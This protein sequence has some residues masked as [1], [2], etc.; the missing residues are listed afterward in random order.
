[1]KF[2]SIVIITVLGLSLAACD[3][4]ETM[5]ANSGSAGDPGSFK[6]DLNNLGGPAL[7][8]P[9]VNAPNASPTV[10]Q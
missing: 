5:H 7:N 8:A 1:M 4:F 2:A 10:A 6:G 9:G 3:T